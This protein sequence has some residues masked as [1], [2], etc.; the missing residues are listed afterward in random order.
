MKLVFVYWA[1]ADQGS[2]N[3]IQGYTR[4]ARVLG[5]EIIV[6]GPPHPGI[7]LNYSRHVA[8]ADAVVFIFEWT[9]HLQHGDQLDLARLVAG[10]P[11]SRRVIID[12][13]GHYNDVLIVDG[14]YNHRDAD[15][16]A[17]WIDLCDGLA[18]KIYQPTLHPLSARVGSFLFYAYDPAWS[19]PLDFSAKE[20]TML[21]VGHAK[22]RW[23]PMKRVL[24]AVESARSRIGRVGLVGIG[25]DELPWWASQMAVEDWY[26]SDPGYL[27]RLGVEVL[28]PVPFEEVIDWMSKAFVNPVLL[29]PIFRRLQFVTPRVFETPAANTIP[30]FGL[31]ETHVRDIY[32]EAAADLVL[33]ADDLEQKIVDVLDRPDH[34]AEMVRGIRRH[35]CAQHSHVARLR[36][37]IDIVEH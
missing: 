5:H 23:K 33:D 22:F 29:R 7:P 14:D 34:Y 15:D 10:V 11:R 31:N 6:Y 16:R 26:Y 12:G 8:A 9:T 25:W 13:D 3:V 30:L 37:L 24:E 21:Y 4:A 18:D 32:G 17:K 19:V 28:P 1:W 20:F 27:R 35:L 2:G 36:Q